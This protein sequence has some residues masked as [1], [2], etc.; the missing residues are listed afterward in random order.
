MWSEPN[1]EKTRPSFGGASG[2]LRFIKLSS[3]FSRCFVSLRIGLIILFFAIAC[4]SAPTADDDNDSN[5][6]NS[7]GNPDTPG[8]WATNNG[9]GSVS[10]RPKPPQ[11]KEATAWETRKLLVTSKLPSIELLNNCQEELR[12]LASDAGS[13]DDMLRLQKNIRL[14]AARNPELYHWCFYRTATLIDWSLERDEGIL[15]REKMPRLFA[16][17]KALWAL[18]L[19][20]DS[21]Y[22][23]KRYFSYIRIRY[24]QIS[25]DYFGRPLEVI[26]T[27][28]GQPYK[29]TDSGSKKKEAGEFKEDDWNF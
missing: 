22:G 25:R 1:S 18:G 21:I 23:T 6:A 16:R 7:S 29:S 17:F 26:T 12:A 4:R 10:G 11:P 27:P 28:L 20:L 15:P 24:I 13:Q 5:M 9:N 3:L 14:A 19:A 8:N 2:F